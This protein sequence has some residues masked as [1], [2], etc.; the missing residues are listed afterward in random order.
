MFQTCQSLGN[1]AKFVETQPQV[2]TTACRRV[3]DVS[4]SSREACKVRLLE[5]HIMHIPS[6][7]IYIHLSCFDSRC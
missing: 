6:L 4:L 1:N 2:S 7:K 5:T 3:K